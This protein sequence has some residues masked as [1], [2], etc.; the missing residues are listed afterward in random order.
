MLLD[1][2]LVTLFGMLSVFSFLYVLMLTIH[3]MSWF[4]RRTAVSSDAEQIAVAIAVALKQ[5]GE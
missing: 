4:V 3:L 1:G 2:L 5:R